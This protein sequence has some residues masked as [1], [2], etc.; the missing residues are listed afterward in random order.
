MMVVFALAVFILSHVVIARSAIKPALTARLGERGY[1][2]AYSLLSLVLLAWVV[3]AVLQAERVTLWIA[4][5][6]ATPFALLVT[7]AAFMLL[8]AGA[9]TPN[10]LSVSFRSAGF[11]PTRPGLVGWLRHPVI[12]GLSL[13]GVAHIPANGSW[14]SLALF[15][16]T[17]LFGLVGTWTTERRIRRRL[18][19]AQW[20]Q[21][22]AGRGHLERRAVVGAGLGLLAWATFLLLHPILFG[23]DPLGQVLAAFG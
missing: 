19:P 7:L 10:P 12:W 3:L 4:L 6:A 5:D 16:G 17:A 23:R 18:G 14:P 11:D 21:I 1:L 20:Q 2:A 13:W 8:G 15:A 22:T 9:V